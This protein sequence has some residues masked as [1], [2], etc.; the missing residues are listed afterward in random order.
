MKGIIIDI[1]AHIGNPE[2][3]VRYQ[4]ATGKLKIDDR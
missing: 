3:T 1:Y 2:I 4:K